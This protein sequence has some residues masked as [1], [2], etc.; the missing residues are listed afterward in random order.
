MKPHYK[1]NL[2]LQLAVCEANYLRLTKLTPDLD[3]CGQ[4]VFAVNIEQQCI[5][6]RIAVVA[7]AKYTT[8]MKV[9]PHDEQSHWSKPPKLSVRLYHDARMAEVVGWE[10]HRS[11][12]P[13]YDYPNKNMYQCDEKA[14][15]NVFLGEWLSYCLGQGYATEKLLKVGE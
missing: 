6:I 3:S 9:V 8:T 5:L 10:K 11:V 2:P 15:M 14:Q 4:W 13:R 7:R 12:K 1:V